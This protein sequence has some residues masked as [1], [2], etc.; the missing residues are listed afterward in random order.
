MVSTARR[1]AFGIAKEMAA[2]FWRGHGKSTGDVGSV[3]RGKT[4]RRRKRTPLNRGGEK[5]KRGYLLSE[6]KEKGGK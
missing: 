2:V 3:Q 6:I 1:D 5:G 4:Q